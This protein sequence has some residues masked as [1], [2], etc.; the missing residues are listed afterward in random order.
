MCLWG[1]LQRRW[2]SES[3]EWVKKIFINASGHHLIPWVGRG[4]KDEFAVWTKICIFSCP[5]AVHQSFWLWSFWFRHRPELHRWFLGLQTLSYTINCTNPGSPACRWKL[6]CGTSKPP[7]PSELIPTINHFLFISIYPTG[8]V[9]LKN[10]EWYTI[11]SKYWMMS[12]FSSI[13]KIPTHLYKLFWLLG[14]YLIINK[15][16]AT[17][18]EVAWKMAWQ[19]R[20]CVDWT[21][22]TFVV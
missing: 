5:C 15:C 6:D 4:K 19:R 9:S 7:Y 13:R 16:C 14:Q 3:V 20:W 10:T 11:W 8:S 21:S 18:K 22:L 17:F 2:T 12:S 1:C